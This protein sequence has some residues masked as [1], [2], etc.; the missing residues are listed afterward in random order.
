MSGTWRRQLEDLASDLVTLRVTTCVVSSLDDRTLSLGE[1]TSH[2]QLVDRLHARAGGDV[3]GEGGLRASGG[4]RRKPRDLR[5]LRASLED[6][7]RARGGPRAAR[8]GGPES[9]ADPVDTTLEDLQTLEEVGAIGP[10]GRLAARLSPKAR[11]AVQKVWSRT[12]GARAVVLTDVRLD[13]DVTT[14]IDE[15]WVRS[16]HLSALLAVHELSLRSSLRMWQ[17]L[18]Q[19]ITSLIRTV[20]DWATGG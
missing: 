15:A 12:P 10:D 2:A 11:V 18:I 13:G 6:E 1:D 7:Q 9:P 20:G 3:A 5:E 19:A 17:H 8:G 14:Q 16:E 4:P